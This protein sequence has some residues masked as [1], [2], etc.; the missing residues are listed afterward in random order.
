[1]NKENKKK[2]IFESV[3]T[4]LYEILNYYKISKKEAKAIRVLT[5]LCN[6]KP[7]PKDIFRTRKLEEK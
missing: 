6:K 7:R 3:K 4:D 2:D 1:M 5:D